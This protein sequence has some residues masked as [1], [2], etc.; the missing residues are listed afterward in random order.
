MKKE[1]DV[2]ELRKRNLTY[3]EI[4]EITGISRTTVGTILNDNDQFGRLPKQTPINLDFTKTT[5]ELSLETGISEVK[6]AELRELE[7]S[8]EMVRIHNRRKGLVRY[9]F[10]EGFEPGPNFVDWVKPLVF[11]LT[12][13]RSQ[14][15]ELFYVLGNGISLSDNINSD[16]DRVYR[17][18]AKKHLKVFV[19]PFKVEDLIEGEILCLK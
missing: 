3:R 13:K 18:D 17:Q 2:L 7:L 15:L 19:E 16:T 5:E 8:K 14:L 6:I 9:L 10:G 4:A 1:Q 11:C 12:P